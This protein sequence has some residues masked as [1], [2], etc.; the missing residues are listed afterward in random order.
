[1]F[2][3]K[4]GAWSTIKWL[5]K[6]LRSTPRPPPLPPNPCLPPPPLPA[7]TFDRAAN[8][9]SPIIAVG[10]PHLLRSAEGASGAAGCSPRGAAEGA[11]AA[12]AGFPRGEGQL[13]GEVLRY[14]DDFLTIPVAGAAVR[15]L[16]TRLLRAPPEHVAAAAAAAATAGMAASG[17]AKAAYAS[18]A[19]HSAS[20][21][22]TSRQ[23]DL[24]AFR[25]PLQI[26]QVSLPS[27]NAWGGSPPGLTSPLSPCSGA[28]LAAHSGRHGRG[29]DDS[30]CASMA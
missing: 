1:M 26:P 25:P 6:Q 12:G 5:R 27:P 17:T 30:R 24:G 7:Q 21:R 8:P 23:A 20:A 4:R 11:A 9:N 16:A 28:W 19:R 13:R 10:S 14:F 15:G 22:A 2:R 3:L 29:Y 18:Q